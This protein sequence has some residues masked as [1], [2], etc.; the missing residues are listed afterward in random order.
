MPPIHITNVL[1]P[2]SQQTPLS[3]LEPASTV[4]PLD[5]TRARP[6]GIPG[7]RDVVIAKYCAWQQA[8]ME[9]EEHDQK[10]LDIVRKDGLDLEQIYEDQDPESFT[11]RGVK[12]GISRRFASARDIEDWAKRHQQDCMGTGSPLEE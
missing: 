7:P 10:A 5:A 1:P 12:W 4:Q 11:K 8:Q 6:L 3:H 2:Q 9:N